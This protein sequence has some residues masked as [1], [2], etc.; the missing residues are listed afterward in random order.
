LSGNNY[1][2]VHKGA[3]PT[4]DYDTEESVRFFYGDWYKQQGRSEILASRE[5]IMMT[6]ANVDNILIK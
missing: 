1:I 3:Q 6:L 4:P 5:E 2:L